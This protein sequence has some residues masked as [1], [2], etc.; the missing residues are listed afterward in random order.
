MK[1]SDQTLAA[2]IEKIKQ[3]PIIATMLEVICRTTGMGFDAVAR[4]TQDR[5][6]A[7]S[8][9]DEIDFGLKDGGELEI[10]TTICDQIRDYGKAVVIDHVAKSSEYFNHPHR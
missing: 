9:R 10:K 8:V 5:W 2:D 1:Y 6:I 4:V 7:C 3:I